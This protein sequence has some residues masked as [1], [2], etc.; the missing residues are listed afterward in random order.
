MKYDGK[1]VLVAAEEA[2]PHAA[3]LSPSAAAYR[4]NKRARYER[5]SLVALWGS[6]AVAL[7]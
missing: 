7:P 3:V 5:A 1:G 4:G 6:A 2:L